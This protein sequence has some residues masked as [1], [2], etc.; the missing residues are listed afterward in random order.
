[1]LLPQL[2]FPFTEIV[3]P[4]VPAVALIVLVVEVPVHPDGNVHV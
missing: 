2:L 1:M 3:P 4:A